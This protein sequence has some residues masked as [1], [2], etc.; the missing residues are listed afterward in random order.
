VSAASGAR[1]FAKAA[2]EFVTTTSG[3]NSTPLPV[4]VLVSALGISYSEWAE[5]CHE[6]KPLWGLLYEEDYP[7][8]ETYGYRTRNYI[9]TEVILRTLNHGTAGHTGEFRCLKKLLAAC[10]SSS[11]PYRTFIHDILVERRGLIEKRFSYEQAMELYE[12]AISAYPKSLGVVEHHKCLAK[13]RL[14]GDSSEVYDDLRKLIAK[15]YDRSIPDQDSPDNLHTSAAATLNQMIKEQ[16]VEAVEG[17][18]SVFEHVTAAL[19]VDQF[20]LHSYHVHAQS[21]MTVAGAVR[22]TNHSAFMVNLERAARI[23]SRALLLMENT[24]TG[25]LLADSPSVSKRLFEDLRQD[26]LL[27]QPDIEGTQQQAVLHFEKTGDQTALGF[28]ARMLLTKAG[29]DK[30]GQLFKRVD[31]FLRQCFK[32][33]ESSGKEPKEELLLCRIELVINWF[34]NQSKGPVYWEQFE[35][36]LTFI[37]KNPRYAHDAIWL[38]Y[39]G[40]AQYNQHKFIEAEACFQTLRSRN[41]P[42]QIRQNIRALYIGDKG[43]PQVLEGKIYSGAQDHRFVF[44]AELENDILVR[45]GDLSGR[46]DELKHFKVGFS[47]YGPLAVDR[48]FSLQV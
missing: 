25:G 21:L 48:Q 2:Y 7:S 43:E 18:E 27:A 19:A 8:A 39:L 13:R 15:S 38:F 16:K 10:T 42:W 37:I 11:P 28:V 30:K 34:L 40:V 44:S 9:V 4:E 46:P 22:S 5:Q 24:T 14:K 36:D 45:R 31:V 47:F 41:L 23:L 12:T 6:K 1:S 32:L 17:G 26:I 20:S 35:T 33:V 3:F 29:Q